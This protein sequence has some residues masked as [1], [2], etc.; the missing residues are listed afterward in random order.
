MATPLP[1]YSQPIFIS[2]TFTD[3]MAERDHLRDI[4]FPELAERL[5]E[6][7]HHLEPVDLRWGVE[8]VSAQ[9]AEKEL[10]V[11]KVCLDEIERC[12]PLLIAILGDRY[13]WIPLEKRMQA[14]IDEKGFV[15]GVQGKSVTALEIEFG[16][17][18]SREQQ[19]RSFF[20]FRQSLPCDRMPQD[21][22]AWFS[23]KHNPEPW[24]PAAVTRLTELKEDIVKKMGKDRVRNS[25]RS[26]IKPETV[27]PV[28]NLGAGR[29]LKIYGGSW[30]IKPKQWSLCLHPPGR[31]RSAPIWMPL[32][33]NAPAG[34]WDGRTCYMNCK[35]WPSQNRK[36]KPGARA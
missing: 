10:L 19:L 34:L 36:L 5:R 1:W 13:G 26:G 24:A 25:L 31:T 11:L 9:Q 17:L 21:V 18:A 7:R 2:S 27:S 16:V 22:A 23:D 6:R 8:T 29:C 30:M 33:R 15:T 32:W 3:M 14:A 12:K 20:Y 35:H 4:V 28:S